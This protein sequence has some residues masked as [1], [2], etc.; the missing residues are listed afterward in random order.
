M[1]TMIVE[2]RIHGVK[3]PAVV[4][5]DIPGNCSKVVEYGVSRVHIDN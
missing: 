2:I 3:E 1:L 4:N 5:E